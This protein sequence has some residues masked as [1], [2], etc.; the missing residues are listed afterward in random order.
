MDSVRHTFDVELEK[1]D[2]TVLRMG[3]FVASMLHDAMDAL[4]R[5]D[6]ALARNVRDRDEVANQLDDEIEQSAMRLLALQQ[7]VASD[8]RRVASVLKATTDLERVGD[9]ASDIAQC[10]MRLAGDP[11]FAPLEDIPEMGRIVEGMIRDALKTYVTRDVVFGKSVRDRD[12]EVDRIYKRVYSQLLEWMERE[13]RVVHQA[14][15]MMFVARYL[16][17]PSAS[18]TIPR[19]S[20]SASPTRRRV[21]CA[22]GAPK[23][24]SAN[25][26]PRR[27]NPDLRKRRRN[28]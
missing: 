23:N 25:T 14:S 17:R 7:P 21:R 24:G 16:E 5:Q 20:S 26:V 9:Y 8:L 19:T 15:E 3:E 6:E 12:K 1:L 28:R 4:V 18:A 22:R 10:A 27:P 2:G 13:P 11:Y